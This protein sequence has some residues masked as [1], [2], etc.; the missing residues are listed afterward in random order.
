MFDH[1]A[2]ICIDAGSPVNHQVGDGRVKQQRP[3]LF[4]KER[5]NQLEAHRTAPCWVCSCGR[6]RRDEVNGNAVFVELGDGQTERID[7][8]IL[9]V[10]L[11]LIANLLGIQVVGDD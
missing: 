5:Q 4:G 8:L 11:G 10:N 9:R 1:A 7:E 6:A 3:Q 2:T